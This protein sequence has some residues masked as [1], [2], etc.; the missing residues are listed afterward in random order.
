MLQFFLSGILLTISIL[1]RKYNIK[2]NNHVFVIIPVIAILLNVLNFSLIYGTSMYNS[3]SG[4]FVFF[5]LGLLLFWVLMII[6]AKSKV[7]NIVYSVFNVILSGTS[8][9]LFLLKPHSP[10]ELRIVEK[11]YT[12]E[13]K[14][15]NE[16][17]Q[18]TNTNAR[19]SREVESLQTKNDT[20]IKEIQSKSKDEEKL[21]ITIND[22]NKK[23]EKLSQQLKS[24]QTEYETK[25]KNEQKFNITSQQLKSLQTKYETKSKKVVSLNKDYI[26]LLKE[27]KE[28]K[29]LISQLTQ[30]KDDKQNEGVETQNGENKLEKKIQAYEEVNAQLILKNTDLEN[31]NKENKKL[32]TMMSNN[33]K[34]WEKGKI[35]VD[36]ANK[37]A[38]YYLKIQ[39]ELEACRKKIDLMGHI[40]KKILDYAEVQ[41]KLK[42][43]KETIIQLQQLNDFL[44]AD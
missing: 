25:S 11:I 26:D 40:E 42:T 36:Q 13:I 39:K 4:M 15:I 24:L 7:E 9:I 33:A 17:K 8:L 10:M 23:N 18:L 21:N 14:D 35:L 28:L 5:E 30:E 43:C 19:L 22:E 44:R 27:S 1:K 12:T 37:T 38:V 32:I 29:N 34:E 20:L 3:N 16:Y 6:R 31:L 2:Q 41:N